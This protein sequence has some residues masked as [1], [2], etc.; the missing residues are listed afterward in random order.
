VQ[1]TAP[2]GAARRNL[3]SMFSF[4]WR[5]FIGKANQVIYAYFMKNGERD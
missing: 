1:K 2:E 3:S 4:W 5:F